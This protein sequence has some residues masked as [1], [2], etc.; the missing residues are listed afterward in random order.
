MRQIF[1][2]ILILAMVVLGLGFY[3]G[4]L[5]LSHSERSEESRKV[6]VNLTVDGDKLQKDV[7]AMKQSATETA[8]K[9]KEG[10]PK[11]DDKVQ[12]GEGLTEPHRV[13]E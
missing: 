6:D 12:I 8:D 4:W 3:R 7:E 1:T 2:V 10:T 5:S 9:I 13:G 11:L